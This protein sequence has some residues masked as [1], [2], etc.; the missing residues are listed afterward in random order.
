MDFDSVALDASSMAGPLEARLHA[1]VSRGFRRMVFAASDLVGHPQGVEAAVALVR[2]AGVRVQALRQLSDFEGLEGP[3]HE[4]KV[5]VAKGLLGLCRAIG[6]PM[7]LVSASG[8]PEAAADPVRVARDLGPGHTIV[9]IL[10]DGGHKYASRF[11]NRD[12]LET[13]GLLQYAG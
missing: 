7:L 5:T 11:Y 6:A 9:T 2:G 3:L 8:V 12:W 1:A 10:C 13:K 4:Y